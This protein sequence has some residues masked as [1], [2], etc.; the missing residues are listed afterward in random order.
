MSTTEKQ[1][2]E[3]KKLN[4]ISQVVYDFITSFSSNKLDVVAKAEKV[5]ETPLQKYERIFKPREN[6]KAIVQAR[7]FIA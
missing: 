2:E 3:A 1:N 7:K 5:V 4:V 6:R